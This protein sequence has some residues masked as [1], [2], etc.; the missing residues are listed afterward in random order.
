MAKI[1]TKV[2]DK[3][4][5]GLVGGQKVDKNDPRLEAYGTV[6]ELNSVI[7]L[8]RVALDRVIHEKAPVLGKH[9]STDRAF[10][11]FLRLSGDLESIQNW[12]FDLG[13]LLACVPEHRESFKLA[14]IAMEKILFLEERIDGATGLLKPLRNFIL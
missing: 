11:S 9:Q 14:P 2:G 5:S 12:L 6:D 8:I 4:R 1:Y 7:G 13:G 3:G 10:D